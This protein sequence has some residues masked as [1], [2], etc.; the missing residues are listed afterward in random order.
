MTRV[1]SS[2]PR[3]TALVVAIAVAGCEPAPTTPPTQPGPGGGYVS[4][5][6]I[7]STAQLSPGGTQGF[8][9]AVTGTA[10]TAVTWSVV[11]TSGG[12]VDASGLYTAP[13]SQGVFHV[14]ATSVADTTR[15]ASATVTVTAAPQP[16]SVTVAPAA[17]LVDAC[18][19]VQLVARVT[20]TSNGVVTW[21]VQEGV[22][23]GTVN[24]S[25]LYT[26]PDVDG[27]YHVVATS[28]ADGTKSATSS[29][30][31]TTRVLSVSVTPVSGTVQTGGGL[32]FAASVTTT[33]GSFPANP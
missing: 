16:V 11:E 3:V 24:S 30:T 6:V 2:G 32:Q 25:G 7:P 1:D 12:T 27:T 17:P 8:S 21:T 10:N 29:V 13:G 23:G 22:A 33:C 5:H 19:T 28:A 14:Q 9:A 18:K 26:A 15:S 20:G 4:L 31:V